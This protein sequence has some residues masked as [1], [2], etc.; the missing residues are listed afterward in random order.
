M[1]EHSTQGPIICKNF[2]S[3]WAR[4][5]RECIWCYYIY[6]RGLRI[7][8]KMMDFESRRPPSVTTLGYCTCW[9]IDWWHNRM[10][11]N[12][13]VNMSWAEII[14]YSLNNCTRKMCESIK[15]TKIKYNL[16]VNNMDQINNLPLSNECSSWNGVTPDMLGPKL[17]HKKGCIV[18]LDFWINY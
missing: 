5:I 3:F 7:R 18:H 6:Y 14:Y 2:Y 15:C 12:F 8:W 17:S 9:S 4:S 10:P 13:Y 16:A 11:T 1:F